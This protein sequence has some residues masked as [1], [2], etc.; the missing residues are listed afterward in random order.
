[1][2]VAGF[3]GPHMGVKAAGGVAG[4]LGFGGRL[5]RERPKTTTV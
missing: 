5:T 3:N 4:A 2:H 1:V